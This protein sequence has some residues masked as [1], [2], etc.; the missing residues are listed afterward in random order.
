MWVHDWFCLSVTNVMCIN[1][2]C[3]E[4]HALPTGACCDLCSLHLLTDI[5][6]VSITQAPRKTHKA[7][8][9][10]YKITE[11]EMAFWHALQTLP[12]EETICHHG[13]ATHFTYR[14]ILIMTNQLLEWIIDLVH[15]SKIKDGQR[16]TDMCQK[17]SSLLPNMLF[18]FFFFFSHELT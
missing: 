1:A 15:V 6:I 5:A 13:M 18:F 8:V 4:C 2:N 3:T 17:F 12:N 9:E 10:P 14:P 7:I 16:V 11:H